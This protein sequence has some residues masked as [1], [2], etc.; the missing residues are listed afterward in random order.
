MKKLNTIPGMVFI[1]EDDVNF[2][3][4]KN[5]LEILEQSGK[6]TKYYWVTLKKQ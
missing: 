2:L 1:T 3:A 5:N 6:N 4:S